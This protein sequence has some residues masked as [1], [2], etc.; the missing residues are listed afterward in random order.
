MIRAL[1]PKAKADWLRRLQTLT[2][3]YNCT[4]H[5]TT[6]YSPFYLMFSRIP[7]LPVDVLF[8]TVL[9]DSD[10]ASYHKYMVSLSNDLKE[11]MLIAQDHA[12]KEQ[13]RC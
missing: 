10:V 5:E 4:A 3:M 12:V 13:K 7:R 11:A 6:G 1:S 2:F 8:H 9:N